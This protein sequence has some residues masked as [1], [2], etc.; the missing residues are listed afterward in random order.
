M[1]SISTLDGTLEK[2]ILVLPL[3]G[4]SSNTG[5]AN[6]NISYRNYFEG[7]KLLAAYL[8]QLAQIEDIEKPNI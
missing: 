2:N 6:E 5:E 7:T 3:V 1:T 4:N 8:L